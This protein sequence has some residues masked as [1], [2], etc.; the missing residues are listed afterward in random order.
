MKRKYF[1]PW[2]ISCC[3]YSTML[4]AQSADLTPRILVVNCYDPA[5]TSYRKNKKELLQDVADSLRLYL[6]DLINSKNAGKG[7]ISEKRLS[8]LNE[9]TGWLDSLLVQHQADI[10]I[11]ILN[12]EAEFVKTDV[13]VEIQYDGSKKR[14][15]RYDLCTT[16][17]YLLAGKNG[18]Y[19]E[20]K[21]HVC[22]FFTERSVVSGLLA[23][24]PDLVGKS[25]WVFRSARK[26]AA[27]YFDY[28][29]N[30]L[31]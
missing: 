19:I 22:E 20:R 14:T 2:I 17:N 13:D 27:V 5:A 23:A 8:G 11:A 24:G 31:R 26:N 18:S 4:I 16:F 9:N 28:I 1:L 12:A 10:V 7:I 6:V 29:R 3:I 21:E 30:S 15:A 25:K